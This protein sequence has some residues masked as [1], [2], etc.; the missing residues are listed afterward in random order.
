M[1]TVQDRNRGHKLPISGMREMPPLGM[2][3]TLKGSGSIIN[4][5]DPIHSATQE[6]RTDGLKGNYQSSLKNKEI[7]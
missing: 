2:L 4:N 7:I 1:R 6:K 5:T 3:Q